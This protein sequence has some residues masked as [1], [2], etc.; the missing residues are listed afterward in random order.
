MIFRIRFLG[1]LFESN[2]D[3][4]W[5]SSIR[6]WWLNEMEAYIT[7]LHNS[8]FTHQIY[9]TSQVTK[10]RHDYCISRLNAVG[11]L[12]ANEFKMVS[13]ENKW[14]T[15][16]SKILSAFPDMKHRLEQSLRQQ[17]AEKS[18]NNAEN[19]GFSAEQEREE[20]QPT[21]TLKSDFSAFQKWFPSFLLIV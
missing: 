2:A 12:Y 13:Y 7:I 19:V 8:V 18:S 4:F 17:S 3:K 21:I 16:I 15:Q 11:P 5:E 9:E 20:K 10:E 14:K 1:S 6:C